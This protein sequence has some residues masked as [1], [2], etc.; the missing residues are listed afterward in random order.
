MQGLAAGRLLKVG[1]GCDGENPGIFKGR[2]MDSYSNFTA[3][4]LRQESGKVEKE[5][6]TEAQNRLIQSGDNG[7]VKGQIR[8][9]VRL[10]GHSRGPIPWM[11]EAAVILSVL[12]G[13]RT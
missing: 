1:H 8:P 12:V 7:P 13:D 11:I 5:P 2:K 10:L 6:Y 3:I 9:L 4:C